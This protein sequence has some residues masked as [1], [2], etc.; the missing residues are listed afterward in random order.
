MT[1]HANADFV[2]IMQENLEP[3]HIDDFMKEEPDIDDFNISNH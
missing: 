1:E 2:H 3:P